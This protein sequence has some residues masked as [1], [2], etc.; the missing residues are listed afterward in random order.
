MIGALIT[1]LVILAVAAVGIEILME[2]IAAG[3][4][5]GIIIGGAI[6][7]VGVIALTFISGMV[8][9]SED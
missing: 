9:K 7:L 3:S 4:L 5:V 6:G 8:V 2:A 1:F